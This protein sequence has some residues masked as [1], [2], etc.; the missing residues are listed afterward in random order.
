MTRSTPCSP[1]SSVS[2]VFMIFCG[3]LARANRLW[4]FIHRPVIVA[5]VHHN[6][7]R[8]V[9]VGAGAFRSLRNQDDGKL[10]AAALQQLAPLDFIS[11]GHG[12]R[13]ESFDALR[14]NRFPGMA[15]EQRRPAFN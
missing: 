14:S 8:K 4:Q 15:A 3:Q 1:V 12:R 5:S 10:I 6:N 7:A 11:A 9:A 2:S 13:E